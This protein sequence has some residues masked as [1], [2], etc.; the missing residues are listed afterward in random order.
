MISRTPNAVLV[1]ASSCPS[2]TR[3]GLGY[4]FSCKHGIRKD[5]HSDRP[6]RVGH[7]EMSVASHDLVESTLRWEANPDTAKDCPSLNVLRSNC[8]KG[9]IGGQVTEPHTVGAL[10]LLG[11]RARTEEAASERKPSKRLDVMLNEKVEPSRRVRLIVVEPARA[12]EPEVTADEKDP[13]PQGLP[14]GAEG[15]TLKTSKSAGP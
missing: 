4:G 14:R 12:R 13:P 9:P 7:R 5:A 10:W 3:G 8:I 2:K 15:R 11:G 1:Q 6:D